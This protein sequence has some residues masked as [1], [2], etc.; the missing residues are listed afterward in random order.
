MNPLFNYIDNED[1]ETIE[2]FIH[3]KTYPSLND[4][5]T[6][7][8]QNPLLFTSWSEYSESNHNLCKEMFNDFTNIELIR[9][10]G[11][12]INQRGGFQAMQ[13]VFYIFQLATHL[14][15]DRKIGSYLELYWDKIGN[16][17]SR[18]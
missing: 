10:N 16:W 1:K 9:K 8:F 13:G 5:E 2:K 14:L 12:I 6:F 4:L 15:G 18:Y 3:G 11:E 7:V 17:E